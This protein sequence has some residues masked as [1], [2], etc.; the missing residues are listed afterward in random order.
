MV[1][2]EFHS[3][4]VTSFCPFCISVSCIRKRT[5]IMA[6]SRIRA[7]SLCGESCIVDW[8]TVCVGLR[9]RSISVEEATVEDEFIPPSCKE[10]LVHQW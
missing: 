1:L 9:I 10:A 3:A 2:S 7:L 6:F 8:V 5:S 4:D